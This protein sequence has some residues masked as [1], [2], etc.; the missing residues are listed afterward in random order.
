MVGCGGGGVV[1]GGSRTGEFLEG[2][3]GDGCD[4]GA[5]IGDRGGFG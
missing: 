4:F 3:V 1:S 5:K 2:C